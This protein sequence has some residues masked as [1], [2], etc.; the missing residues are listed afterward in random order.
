MVTKLIPF[1]LP[2]QIQMYGFNV[3][4]YRNM[5]EARLGSNGIVGLSI[6]IQVSTVVV[7][8][9]SVRHDPGV[10]CSVVVFRAP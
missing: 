5:S 8:C 10:W 3:D 9:C 4:L 7:L 1:S 6:M 2:P